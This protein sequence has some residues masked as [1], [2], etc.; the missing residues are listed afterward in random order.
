[1]NSLPILTVTKAADGSSITAVD[2]TVTSTGTLAGIILYLTKLNELDVVRGMRLSGPQQTDLLAAGVELAATEF[3]YEEKFPDAVHL[4]RYNRTYTTAATLT[5]TSGEKLFTM[6][7]GAP[8]TI[9]ENNA[10]GF[11][12]TGGED[13]KIYYLD[14]SK[15]FTA[16]TGYV[17]EAL[18]ELSGAQTIELVFEG[19]THFYYFIDGNACLL[20]DIG[21]WAEK[22]CDLSYKDVEKRHFYTIAIPVKFDQGGVY[23][24]QLLIDKLLSYCENNCGCN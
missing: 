23:D 24:A 10:V 19:T 18:P 1:M 20:E 5:F 14:R 12:L 4:V 6:T 16:T 7:G 2:A 17:T 15:P 3:G 22:D 13:N 21:V 11:V 9:F 8:A